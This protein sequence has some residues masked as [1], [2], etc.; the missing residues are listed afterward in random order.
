MQRRKADQTYSEIEAEVLSK[1]LPKAIVNI[2][3]LSLQCCF[4]A[5]YN[6][7]FKGLLITIMGYKPLLLAVE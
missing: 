6:A 4:L 2:V 7:E 1:Q 3:C 5:E